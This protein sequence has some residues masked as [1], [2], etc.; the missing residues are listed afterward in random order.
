[1]YRSKKQKILE[2]SN[3]KNRMRYYEKDKQNKSVFRNL[4]ST[5]M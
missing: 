4:F 3:K 5:I 1:M 2:R